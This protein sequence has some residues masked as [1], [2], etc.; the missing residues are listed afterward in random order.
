MDDQLEM[1]NAHDPPTKELEHLEIPLTRR[2]SLVKRAK[3]YSE[4]FIQPLRSLN[5]INPRRHHSRRAVHERPTSLHPFWRPRGFWDEFDSDEEDF[6]DHAAP[7]EPLPK[8][9]DTSEVEDAVPKRDTFPRKM[10]KRMPGFR[11]TGGFMLGN[12]L[13]IGRHGT[14]NRRPFIEP[15]RHSPTNDASNTPRSLRKRKSEHILRTLAGST[16]SLGRR[17]ALDRSFARRSGLNGL[18]WMPGAMRRIRVCGFGYD[19]EFDV[20]E[21]FR[22]VRGQK[23]E[24]AAERR[25]VELRA[26]IGTRIYHGT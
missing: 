15:T 14:N 11:G 3:R 17:R 9:G 12:S 5:G 6:H 23:A 2:Q 1:T 19:V 18:A 4:S 24:R 20:R 22:R 7:A 8:G 26:M 25:R 10:S 16:D 13:G 21:R